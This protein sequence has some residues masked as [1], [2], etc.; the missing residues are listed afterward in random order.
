[1]E[2]KCWSRRLRGIVP[3][4]LPGCLPVALPFGKW[5]L[6]RQINSHSGTPTLQYHCSRIGVNSHR[7]SDW[8]VTALEG[9]EM[10]SMARATAECCSAACVCVCVLLSALELRHLQCM[11]SAPV[12]IDEGARRY[13]HSHVMIPVST[14]DRGRVLNSFDTKLNGAGGFCLSLSLETK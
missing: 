1:M 7:L 14:S 9:I 2:W 12:G 8:Y 10:L 13:K 11:E 5:H 4:C 3:A 6:H